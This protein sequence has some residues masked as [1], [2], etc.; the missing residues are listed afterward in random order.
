VDIRDSRPGDGE[1]LAAMWL[2]EGRYY[3]SLDPDAFQAPTEDGL[4]E[5]IE[6]GLARTRLR[7]GIRNLVAEL[8]GQLAG[9]VLVRIEPDADP[10]RRQIVREVAERRAII[11]ALGTA[12]AFQRRGVAT[13][14]VRLRRSGRASRGR[15][16][17][18]RGR[19]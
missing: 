15:R 3:A 8:D 1:A 11:D 13:A 10:D 16:G 6:D 17:S 19:T 4:A 7:E 12:E 2:E 9:Y 18:G 14:L 5:W